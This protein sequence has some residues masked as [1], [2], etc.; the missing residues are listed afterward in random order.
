MLE[1]LGRTTHAHRTYRRDTR[2]S[3][4]GNPQSTFDGGK[5]MDDSETL[6]KL[7][8]G[9]DV[10]E[11]RRDIDKP[12]NVRWLLRNIG[13]RNA[14]G[15]SLTKAIQLLINLTRDSRRG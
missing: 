13:I 14:K 10:P 3:H 6:Q 4:A 5:R 12:A 7:I 15:D 8:E 9:F 1:R 2:A 11:M